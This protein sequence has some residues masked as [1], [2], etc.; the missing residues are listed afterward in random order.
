MTT[1]MELV[2]HVED[3]ASGRGPVH[4][5]W[6][7]GDVVRR[8]PETAWEA[9]VLDVG[10]AWARAL[11]RVLSSPD[12][13]AR[14]TL[15]EE[16]AYAELRRDG[17]QLHCVLG[18]QRWSGEVDAQ[19]LT[20]SVVTLLRATLLAYDLRGLAPDE[21]RREAREVLAVLVTAQASRPAPV[22]ARLTETNRRDD[23]RRARLEA[24]AVAS[25]WCVRAFDE[26]GPIEIPVRGVFDELVVGEW[27]HL[28][29]MDER[30]WWMRLGDMRVSVSV[31]APDD[32][33]VDVERGHHATVNG[34]TTMPREG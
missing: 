32:V 5:R 3:R 22:R 33:R 25:V 31:N 28:E 7:E 10:A 11:T 6:L 16:R 15:G 23:E 30:A 20:L 24:A 8:W 13:R 19:D 17:E 2:G 9:S 26:G 21:R 14:I 1:S 4:L 12:E 29:W 18:E 27:L 34:K